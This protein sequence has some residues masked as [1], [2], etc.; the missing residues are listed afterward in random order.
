[1][2]VLNRSPDKSVLLLGPTG[3][4]KT[5]IGHLIHA[6]S[7]RGRGP[8]HREQAA[9]NTASDFSLIKLRWVGLGRGSGLANA[10]K[11]PRLGL[12]LENA[13]GTIFLD[14]V[15]ATSQT[16]QRFICDVLDGR[17]IPVAAS[18]AKPLLP[19]VRHDFRRQRRSRP[20]GS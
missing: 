12:L 19:D 6:S 15:H 11:N 4:G 8:Y 20:C 9:A 10:P 1:M 13:G 5:E 16:F 2:E 18:H 17:P 14:E 3:V 7:A